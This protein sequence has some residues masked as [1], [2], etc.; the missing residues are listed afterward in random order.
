MNENL[1]LREY[2]NESN[3]KIDGRNIPYRL[4]TAADYLLAKNEDWDMN[5]VKQYEEVFPFRFIMLNKIMAIKQACV[6]LMQT[7]HSDLSLV[8]DLRNLK[9]H[10]IHEL[11]TV[12][13]EFD[14]ELVERYTCEMEEK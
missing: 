2:G 8:K 5:D 4:V 13:V 1:K 6:L 10:L 14:E 9:Q 12:G 11:R 3:L 7:S